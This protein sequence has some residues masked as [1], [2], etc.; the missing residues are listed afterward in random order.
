MCESLDSTTFVL[1]H[2]R[3]IKECEGREVVLGRVYL[4]GRSEHYLGQ[5]LDSTS[6]PFVN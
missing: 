3:M 4:I 2:R 5:A 6:D 1:R